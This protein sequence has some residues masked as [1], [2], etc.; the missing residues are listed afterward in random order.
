MKKWI[1]SG[2]G[3]LLIVVIGYM[4]YSTL[5]QDD[6]A[7]TEDSHGEHEVVN[8]NETDSHGHGDH[9]DENP[10][11]VSEVKVDL[12]VEG[13]EMR[14]ALTNLKGEPV[15]NLEINHEK[16][17]H[18][19]VVDEHLDQYYHLHPE[20]VGT[21]QFMVKHS[22]KEG[23]YK[24]FVDIKP[25]ELSYTV[26]PIEFTIGNI[27][28]SH[29]HDHLEVDTEFQ[30]TI[31]DVTVSLNITSFKVQEDVTLTFSFPEGTNLEPYLGAMGHVVILDEEADNYIHVHPVSE[32]DTIFATSF[33][34]AGIYKVWGEF[35]IN[36][37][38]YTYPF[39]IEISE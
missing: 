23:A 20:E 28:E 13:D 29:A 8:E 6:V 31:N 39:V 36:G 19:I 7:Q 10:T 33:P 17:L 37:Q 21:G 30:K 25:S 4:I 38:V 16:L 11:G 1:L 9:Q 24:A 22:F 32:E 14:I 3:Y 34:K 2:I 5:F 35:Q 27:E 12:I 18:L 15:T 26:S